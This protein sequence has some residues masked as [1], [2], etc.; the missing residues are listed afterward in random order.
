MWR[1][2]VVD[3]VSRLRADPEVDALVAR[4][5]ALRDEVEPA[6]P[7]PACR[8]TDVVKPGGRAGPDTASPVPNVPEEFPEGVY[9]KEVT[10]Q[11]LMDVGVNTPDAYG[12]KG[13]WT[14]MLR[15]GRFGPEDDRECPGSTYEIV[16]GRI[17]V[18]L[19]PEGP[20]CG[21]AAGKV[22]FSAGWQLHGDQLTLTDV[23]SGHGSDVLIAGL[24]G[25]APWTRLE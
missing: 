17:V 9:R 3:L 18:T 7:V 10:A 6:P 2:A 5:D 21:E 24:F 22:L 13:L 19:G 11:D 4:I 15:D 20:G 14:M 8:G 12:H 16:D 1:A 25:T 23:K